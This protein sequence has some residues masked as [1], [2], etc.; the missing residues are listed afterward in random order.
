[1]IVTSSD[2]DSNDEKMIV[3][4]TRMLLTEVD[5]ESCVECNY[6]NDRARKIRKTF[7]EGCKIKSGVVFRYCKTNILQQ[8]RSCVILSCILLLWTENRR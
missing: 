3:N 4:D 7:P 8:I 2:D 6:Y 5:F 1:M